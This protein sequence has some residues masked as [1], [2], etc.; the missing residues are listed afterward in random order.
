MPGN[1]KVLV[2]S[3][4]MMSHAAFCPSPR[5]MPWAMIALD[6]SSRYPSSFTKRCA[7]LFRRTPPAPRSASGASHLTLLVS[8]LGSTKP[9]G[10][11]WTW[12]ICT[13]AAPAPSA[14]EIPSPVAKGPLVVGR[15]AT[16][17][18]NRFNID[19]DAQ[20]PPVARTTAS[21]RIS[22]SL[23][24]TSATTPLTA[25]PSTMS[26]VTRVLFS[27]ATS[28]RPP[29]SAEMRAKPMFV[30]LAPAGVS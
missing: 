10:W 12:S 24:S 19:A 25:P 5:S 2:A 15:C 20:Y 7:S 13:I 14:R 29:L 3:S 28:F 18:A 21:A 8:S 26:E 27:I 30:G 4:F 23:P 16:S 6:T 22:F 17:P 1:G 11:I 9:E